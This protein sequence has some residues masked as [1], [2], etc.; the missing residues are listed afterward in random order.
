MFATLRSSCPCQSLKAPRTLGQ[1]GL[2]RASGHLPCPARTS[3]SQRWDSVRVLSADNEPPIRFNEVNVY[4]NER[5][6]V[7]R[8]ALPFA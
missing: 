2:R 8:V 5:L 7:G 3:L 4:P 1:Q 6:R